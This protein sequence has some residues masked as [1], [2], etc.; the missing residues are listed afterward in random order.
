MAQ[1]T[2]PFR[3]RAC[4]LAALVTC[5][6][7][8]A[9]ASSPDQI[10]SDEADL[11]QSFGDPK[12]VSIATG[13]SQL[14][15]RAPSVATVIT[16]TDIQV[17]GATDLDEVMETI[18]G[19]HV[20]RIS[21]VYS[22]SY[23]FRGINLGANPQVLILIN[24]IPATSV[25]TGN[26]G[27][28]WVGMPLEHVARIEVIRG[29][30]S[31]LYGA[32]AAAGVIN[33]ITKSADEIDGLTL[34][35][36]VGSFNS[37]DSWGLYGG[38]WG[39]IKV[40]GYLRTGATQG[41]KSIIQ[42]DAQTGLDNLVGTHASHA[43]GA[44]NN[45]RDYIDGTLDLSLNKWRWR[46]GIR[47]RDNVG[48]GAGIASAL[49]P[50]GQSRM[51]SVTSDLSYDDDAIAPNWVVSAQLS[52]SNYSE[53]SD[54][55]LFP[56]G[57]N[58]GGPT[59]TDG[60]IGNPY[61]W[62]RHHRLQMAATY[63]G[64]QQHSIRLGLGAESA[65]IYRIRE[66]KNFNPDFTPI[67]TGSLSDVTD[68]SQSRPFLR[69]HSR[70]LHYAYSQD[71][72]RMAPDWTLTAGLRHDH[73]SDF[74]SS[75]NPRLALVWD[76]AYNITTKLMASSAF[77]PPSFTELYAINNPV[78]QGNP[79]LKPESIRTAEAAVAWHLSPQWQLGVN[80]FHYKMDNIIQLV[81]FA[82]QNTGKLSG[83]GLELETTWAANKQWQLSGNY[84]FQYSIDGASQH[85]AGNAPHHQIYARADWRMSPIWSAHAQV[86]WISRQTRSLNDTRPS[87]AG[88][89]TVDLTVRSERQGR[90][91]NTAISI[92]NLLDAE[93]RE[94]SIYD[95]SGGQPYI[96][97]PNDYPMPGRSLYVQGTYT[98]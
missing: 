39:P 42:A 43:P 60:M 5:V 85:D 72:W 61:K 83:N 36:R 82:Y 11:A 86:N 28:G 80:V 66:S 35:A 8:C 17:M 24:G 91:W 38:Q 40:A 13:S 95:R 32:D 29:P 75:T 81:S 70:Q 50:T 21:Q 33:I 4:A 49:D 98:F 92:R 44:V 16:A 37:H 34:G 6:A 52:T 59:F 73:Y 30:G 19:V 90:G 14:L 97:L 12:M 47:D 88:Y 48:S 89:E 31:A 3:H 15:S 79:N 65:E 94:P 58:F 71:E 9:Y 69:P 26:R 18:P 45:A 67:G 25:V 87:L 57:M 96:S 22:P 54:L 68:V 64:L 62:E 74:G 1:N 51:R 56:A 27:N 41:A 23:V 46:F 53:K 84:S 55:T 76:T 10:E 78:A 77:R 63:T 2:P 20:A 93:V 7:S